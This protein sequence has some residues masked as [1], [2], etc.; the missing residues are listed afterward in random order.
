MEK[1]NGK[2]TSIKGIGREAIFMVTVLI[3]VL[4]GISLWAN[5]K[6]MF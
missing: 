1:G 3:L 6:I 2:A 4:M 5:G